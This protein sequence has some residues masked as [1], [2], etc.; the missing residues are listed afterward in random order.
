MVLVEILSHI[1]PVAVV[2]SVKLA[3][4]PSW[5]NKDETWWRYTHSNPILSS[6]TL[7]YS[8]SSLMD[9]STLLFQPLTHPFPFHA[10][11]LLHNHK[12]CCA[13]PGIFGAV[14]VST[15][16]PSGANGIDPLISALAKWSRVGKHGFCPHGFCPWAHW[17]EWQHFSGLAQDSLQFFWY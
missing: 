3:K 16:P 12:F 6:I 7:Q 5:D 8:T 15:C 9:A 1:L 10:T 11:L 17:P 2:V 4:V 13:F 14:G